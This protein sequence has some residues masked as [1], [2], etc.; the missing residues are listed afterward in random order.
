MI[1]GDDRNYYD[2]LE[3]VPDASPQEI[4]SAYLRAKNAYR[5]DS[6]ALYTLISEEETEV[7]LRKIEEAYQILSSPERRRDYDRGHGLLSADDDLMAQTRAPRNQK[8]ISIDRVPPM[9]DTHS[10]MSILVSPPTDF[11][12]P[13]ARNNAT[14]GASMFESSEAPLT[15]A[16]QPSSEPDRFSNSQTRSETYSQAQA[17]PHFQQTRSVNSYVPPSRPQ[18]ATL[19]HPTDQ[20]ND[21][22]IAQEIQEETEWRGPFLR[23]VR[24]ARNVPVEELSEYSKISK[25][26]ILAIEEENYTKLPASVYLRGFLTQISKYLKLPHEKIATAYIARVNLARVESEKKRSR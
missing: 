11:A 23:K 7:L 3:L 13:A 26:Y 18:P 15:S 2:L 5:K 1:L 25:T 10:D 12:T 21:Q 6:V 8:I 20:F 4:R 24:E 14:S 17:Q 16:P 19:Q 9:E 22:A